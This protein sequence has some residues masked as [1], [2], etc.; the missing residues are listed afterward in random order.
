MGDN[1]IAAIT[2]GV[3]Y[4][5]PLA[6]TM[7]G[8][9]KLEVSPA[10]VLVA[11]IIE[12]LDKMTYPSEKSD[13]PL[14]TSHLPDGDNVETD[15]G[16]VYDTTGL[17]DGRLMTGLVPQ[18]PGIQ[19]RIRSRVYETGFNKI[20]DIAAS[21]DEVSN[22]SFVIA[23]GEFEIQNASR[24]SPVIPLGLEVGS[25]KRRFLFTVNFILTVKK[26]A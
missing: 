25:T 13:W 8:S 15:C 3:F 4:T 10:S 20:E 16:V 21:L 9:D 7:A 12:E 5:T 19:L 18:H 22:S 6:R 1:L 17:M 11:Y 26:L 23:A 2:G 24:T 14:Y